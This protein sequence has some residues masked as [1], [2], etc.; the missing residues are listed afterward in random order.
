VTIRPLQ[1]ADLEVVSALGIRSKASWG[2]SDDQMR[3]FQ[4]ELIWDLAMLETRTAFV[5]TEHTK[6]LGYYSLKESIPILVELEHLFVDPNH[7]GQ[8]VGKTLSRHAKET[9]GKAGYTGMIILSDPNAAGF[10][11]QMQRKHVRDIPSS[12]QGRS[13]PSMKSI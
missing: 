11:D 3:T 8:G 5:T 4:S 10:Y 12:I 2:Y 6:V 9:A 1:Q 13:I 7:F